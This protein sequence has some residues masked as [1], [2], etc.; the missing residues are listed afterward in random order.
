MIPKEPR[1][2]SGAIRD[3]R[4]AKQ[5]KGQIINP[6]RY[7]KMGGFDGPS[8]PGSGKMGMTVEKPMKGAKE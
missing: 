2:G 5:N 7:M 1:A 6:P 8:K 3:P 4:D